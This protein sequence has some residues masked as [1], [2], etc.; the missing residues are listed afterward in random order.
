MV[1]ALKLGMM[2][3]VSTKVN[4]LRERKLAGHVMRTTEMF[5]KVIS[6]TESSMAK[7]NITLSTPERLMKVSSS[8]TKSTEKER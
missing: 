8:I 5:M 4:L 1:K 6:S 2:V 7:A 3:R